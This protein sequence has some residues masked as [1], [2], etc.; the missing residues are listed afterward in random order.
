ME[1]QT[2]KI[3]KKLPN[4]NKKLLHKSSKKSHSGVNFTP[5]SRAKLEKQ[6]IL[7]FKML[8]NK[9][10]WLKRLLM[11]TYSKSEM[12][13]GMDTTSIKTRVKK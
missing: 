10:E 8:L 6:F 5:D 9:L 13:K 2:I 3:I 1:I 12:E 4:K 11:I 7:N